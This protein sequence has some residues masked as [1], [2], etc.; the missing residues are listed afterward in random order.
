MFPKRN[1]NINLNYKA[2]A[3]SLIAWMI[4]DPPLIS[5]KLLLPLIKKND[6]EGAGMTI[7]QE[8]ITVAVGGDDSTNV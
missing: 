4:F 3:Q 2:V 6:D 1:I 8:N 5:I 7:E